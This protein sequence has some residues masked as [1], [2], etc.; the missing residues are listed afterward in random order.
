MLVNSSGKYVVHK[1]ISNKASEFD[2]V[3]RRATQ[4]ERQMKSDDLKEEKN[5]RV[6]LLPSSTNDLQVPPRSIE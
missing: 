5:T 4:G 3:S 2:L 6:D 1:I